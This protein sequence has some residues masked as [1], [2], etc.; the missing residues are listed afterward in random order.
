MF[1]GLIIRP[2]I[3]VL[4][5]IYFSFSYLFIFNLLTVEDGEILLTEVFVH[6]LRA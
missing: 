4:P 1:Q 3:R 2:S 5:C 6:G